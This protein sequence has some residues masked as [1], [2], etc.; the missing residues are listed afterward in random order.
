MGL[1]LVRFNGTEGILRCKAQE[2]D[3]TLLLLQSIKEI[4]TKK[5]EITTHATSGTIRGITG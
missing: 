5:V 2:K 4:E 1:W 3:T